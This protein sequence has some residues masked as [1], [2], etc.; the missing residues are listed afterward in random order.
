MNDHEGTFDGWDVGARDSPQ[1]VIC[2]IV[3]AVTDEE[4]ADSKTGM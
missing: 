1:Q 4:G 2:R 3:I